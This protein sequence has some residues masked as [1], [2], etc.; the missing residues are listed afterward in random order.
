MI[1]LDKQTYKFTYVYMYIYTQIT[2][3]RLDFTENKPAKRLSTMHKYIPE[4]MKKISLLLS[5]GGLG[6]FAAYVYILYTYDN[7]FIHVNI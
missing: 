2:I 1:Y 6:I 5:R 7:I 3:I 4:H